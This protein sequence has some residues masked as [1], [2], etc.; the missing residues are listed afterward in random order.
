M[1]FDGRIALTDHFVEVESGEEGCHWVCCGKTSILGRVNMT[2]YLIQFGST[3][4]MI[5]GVC[6]RE[7]IPGSR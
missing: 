5:G 7:D 2:I 4:R 3:W 1:F 6:V